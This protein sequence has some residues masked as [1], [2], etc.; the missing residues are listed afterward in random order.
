MYIQEIG[1]LWA[2]QFKYFFSVTQVIISSMKLDK[3]S[4]LGIYLENI[5]LKF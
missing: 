1:E 4:M 3:A 5:S 2:L